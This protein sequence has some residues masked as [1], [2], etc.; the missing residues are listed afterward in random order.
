MEDVSNVS[1]EDE[2]LQLRNEGKISAGEYEELLA[3]MR[4]SVSNEGEIPPPQTEKSRSVFPGKG[5][6]A[7]TIAASSSPVLKL[8]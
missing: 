8:I 5:S 3:T 7:D 4:K 6:P 1:S 2:L